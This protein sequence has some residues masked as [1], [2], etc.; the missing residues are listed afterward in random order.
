MAVVVNI[1]R[2]VKFFNP[3]SH[4]TLILY[5]VM[6]LRQHRSFCYHFSFLKHFLKAEITD[7]KF[8]HFVTGVVCALTCNNST[9]KQWLPSLS[10]SYRDLGTFASPN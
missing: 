1:V 4:K 5:K 2:N 7:D 10:C 3:M 8:G 6:S 9:K